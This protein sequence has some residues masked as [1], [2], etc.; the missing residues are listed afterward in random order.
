MA[1][2]LSRWAT[3]SSTGTRGSPGA[4]LEGLG[5]G[6]DGILWLTECAALPRPPVTEMIARGRDTG[7]PV[8][9]A[10]TSAQVAADLAGLT[11]V[12]VAL[13]HQD[14]A[15][16]HELTGP[17]AARAPGAGSRTDIQPEAGLR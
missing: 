12:V 11:N 14:T 1:T 17:A 15:A 16:A 4:A 6:G 8:L 2:G 10:T 7:L 5:V 3:S 9:A 13:P